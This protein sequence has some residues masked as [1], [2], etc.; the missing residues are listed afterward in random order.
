L[1]IKKYL[2]EQLGVSEISEV[3]KTGLC[4][5]IRGQKPSQGQTQG[6]RPYGIAFRAGIDAVGAPEKNSKDLFHGSTNSNSFEN[7]ND[8][9]IACLLGTAALILDNIGSISEDLVVRLI[10]EPASELGEGAPAMIA[11]GVLDGIDEIYGFGLFQTR[12]DQ[13]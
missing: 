1:K 12:K 2:S 6:T 11:E 3:A 10:F 4:V 13:F 8:G 7:G 9:Q 5:S